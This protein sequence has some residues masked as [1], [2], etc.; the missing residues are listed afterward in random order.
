MIN[1]RAQY[2]KRIL[3][4]TILFYFV[5][6]FGNVYSQGFT[7]NQAIYKV[8]AQLQKAK[9]Y[10]VDANI[11][12]DLPFIRM[13]PI[14][15]KIF[16][17]QPSKFKV[18]SKSIAI[19]PRQGFD[20][21]NKILSDTNQFTSIAQNS[22]LVGKEMAKVISL[23]PVE[24]TTDLILAKLWV[25]TKLNVVLKSLLTTK[26]NGTILTEYSY[27]KFVNFGLP[28]AMTFTVDIKKFKIPKSI[29]A[30]INTNSKKQENK[31][32]KNM[33]GKIIISLS[34]YMINSGIQDAVFVK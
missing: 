17:K 14:S 30:D 24:D 34:N 28:D 6:L 20:Q 18:E 1:R 16:V 23:I 2:F 12:V 7:A 22:E 25:D 21:L 8:Y 27:G 33:K 9:D 3:N 13:L 19:V 32:T 29:A 31:D 15:A 10:K 11:K 26:T 4:K 5:F